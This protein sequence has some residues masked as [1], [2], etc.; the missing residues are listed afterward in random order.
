M[1]ERIPFN[2]LPVQIRNRLSGLVNQWC[3]EGSVWVFRRVPLENLDS[4]PS[5]VPEDDNEA[6]EIQKY[7][8]EYLERRGDKPLILDAELWWIIDGFHHL[9]AFREAVEEDDTLPKVIECWIR[10]L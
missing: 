7:K 1:E 8:K 5:R 10:V 3:L 9:T 2:G 6:N 4:L